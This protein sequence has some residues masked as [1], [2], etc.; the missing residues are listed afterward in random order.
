MASRPVAEKL[1]AVSSPTVLVRT[2]QGMAG[3]KFQVIIRSDNGVVTR[4]FRRLNDA[5][6]WVRRMERPERHPG[7]DSAGTGPSTPTG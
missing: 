5:R 3:T 4:T 7:L 2:R 6:S 1:A